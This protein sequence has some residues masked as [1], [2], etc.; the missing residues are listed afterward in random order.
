[1]SN[2]LLKILLVINFI[3][4]SPFAAYA[5]DGVVATVDTLSLGT[6]VLSEQLPDSMVESEPVINEEKIEIAQQEAENFQSKQEQ[7]TTKEKTK[8]ISFNDLIIKML[9]GLGIAV[10]SIIVI[11]LILFGLK[12]KTLKTQ[13]AQSE[14]PEQKKENGLTEPKNISEAVALF[15]K[16]RLKK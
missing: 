3:T 8:F 5:A 9:K 13:N 16:N 15:V 2:K 12:K 1:M 10:V 4:I 11:A 7:Q 6:N 14:E